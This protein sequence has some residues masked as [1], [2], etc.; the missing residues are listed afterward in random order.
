[1]T[2]FDDIR[3]HMP[4]NAKQDD[5]IIEKALSCLPARILLLMKSEEMA[6]TCRRVEARVRETARSGA[7]S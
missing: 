2:T 3:E 5:A 6:M 7:G 1:M 4:D